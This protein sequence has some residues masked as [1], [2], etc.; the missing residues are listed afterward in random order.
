M[1]LLFWI[2][3]ALVAY[4]FAGYPLCIALL[5][6]LAPRPVARGDACPT[7]TAVMAVHDPGPMLQRKLDNLLA[8]DYPTDRLDI[9]VACDGCRDGSADVA[10]A[11]DPARVR[12]L[13]F[14]ERRGKSRCLDDAVATA[15]GEILLMID[16]RQRIEPGALRALVAPFADPAVGAVGGELRFEDPDTGFAASVDA[17]WRYEKA[18]RHA[19]SRSGSV[20]GV[21]GAFYAMRRALYAPL[22]PGTVLDDVLTPMRLVRDGHRVVFE[23][24]AIA[25]DVASRDATSER[26]RKIRTLAGNYQL[27]AL[28]PWLANPFANP[29]WWRFTSHKLLRLLAPWLLVALGVTTLVLAPRHPFYLACLVAATAAVG[30]VAVGHAVPRIGRLLPVRLLTA[31]LHMNLAAAQA[32]FAFA[33]NRTLHLW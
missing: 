21:S 31:F 4:T 17:Y 33:R 20:I 27:L 10:R 15:T 23:P 1:S 28:A 2:S 5:A 12:V 30:A 29:A 11:N 18:I 14:E 19:E 7:V 26:R 16:V 22:P 13:A 24:G 8:L 6:R 9:V 25:W 3:A 32:L